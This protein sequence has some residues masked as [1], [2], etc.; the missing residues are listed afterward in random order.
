LPEEN[1]ATVEAGTVVLQR[2][3]ANALFFTAALPKAVFTGA[4][5]LT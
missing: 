5:G 1:T 2:S 4:P 3:Q